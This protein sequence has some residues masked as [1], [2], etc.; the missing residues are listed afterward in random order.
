VLGETGIPWA[1]PWIVA[2]FLGLAIAGWLAYVTRDRWRRWL[3]ERRE[4][5]DLVRDFRS[6]R[7]HDG[8]TGGR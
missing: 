7:R 1:L 5:R 6:R 4:E 2:I 8:T 3:R